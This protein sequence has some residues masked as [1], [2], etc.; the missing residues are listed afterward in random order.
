[1]EPGASYVIVKGLFERGTEC[2]DSAP[3]VVGSVYPLREI[4]LP[5]I[6]E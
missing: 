5:A 1:M 6:I 3:D 2:N 4:A